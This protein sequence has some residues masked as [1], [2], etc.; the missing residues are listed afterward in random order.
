MTRCR[1][2]LTIPVVPGEAMHNVELACD[3]DEHENVLSFHFDKLRQLEW[4]HPLL[5]AG[6]PSTRTDPPK[7]MNAKDGCCSARGGE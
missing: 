2:T 7:K 6:V 5:P 4:R 1:D 3:L